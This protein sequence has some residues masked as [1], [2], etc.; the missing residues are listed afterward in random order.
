M[1]VSRLRV[2]IWVMT[3]KECGFT[4][5]SIFQLSGAPVRR[6]LSFSVVFVLLNVRVCYRR[7]PVISQWLKYRPERWVILREAQRIFHCPPLHHLPIRMGF[8]IYIP[9]NVSFLC[10]CTDDFCTRPST[11]IN[12]ETQ[13][14]HI[15][16]LRVISDQIHKSI[17]EWFLLN[18]KGRCCNGQPFSLTDL[19]I[20]C[21]CVCVCL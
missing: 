11:F 18:S 5:C 3:K 16:S 15:L 10:L 12:L 7:D 9:L 20:V 4:S 1:C 14:I 13:M 8:Y 6:L 21:V 19:Q 17:T 2:Q